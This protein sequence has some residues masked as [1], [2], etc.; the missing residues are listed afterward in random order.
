MFCRRTS[1]ALNGIEPD[2]GKKATGKEAFVLIKC[3]AGFIRFMFIVSK[4]SLQSAAAQ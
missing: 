1:I 3:N 2:R 4:Q